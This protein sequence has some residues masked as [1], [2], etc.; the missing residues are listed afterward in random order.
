MPEQRDM[1]IVCPVTWRGPAPDSTFDIHHRCRLDNAHGP[2]HAC[3]CGA[4]QRGSDHPD[5]V[6]RFGPGRIPEPR[7][8]GPVGGRSDR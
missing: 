2:L 1:A 3:K 6:H 7:H 8:L 4:T 5:G